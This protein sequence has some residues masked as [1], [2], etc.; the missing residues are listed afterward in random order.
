MLDGFNDECLAA[1]PDLSLSCLRVIRE[2][3]AVIG[4]RGEP[5]MIV[6]DNGTGRQRW[7]AELGIEW[8]YIVPRKPLR[9]VNSFNGRLRDKCF[10]NNHVFTTLAEARRIVEAWRIDYNPIS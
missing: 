3:E 9:L 10:N 4:I 1:I 8:H 6:S 5:A 7:A 2:L